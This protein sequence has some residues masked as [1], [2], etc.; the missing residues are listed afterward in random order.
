MMN[1]SLTEKEELI[2]SLSKIYDQLEELELAL[3][4]SFSKQRT[5]L[6]KEELGKIFIAVNRL[7]LIE[8]ELAHRHSPESKDL[9]YPSVQVKGA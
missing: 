7:S 5:R 9:G 1:K 6:N 3:V 2:S 4:A 8:E